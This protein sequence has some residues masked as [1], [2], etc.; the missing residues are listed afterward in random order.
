MLKYLGLWNMKQPDE[1]LEAGEY[2]MDIESK[3]TGPDPSDFPKS[4][5]PSRK[6]LPGDKESPRVRLGFFRLYI[7]K[8]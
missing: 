5:E 4:K 1:Y 2:H 3:R 8:I 7:I 6:S